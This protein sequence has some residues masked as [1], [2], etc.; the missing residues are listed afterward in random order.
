[1]S[2]QKQVT[3]ERTRM[4]PVREQAAAHVGPVSAVAVTPAGTIYSGAYD[5]RL[6]EWIRRGDS[7]VPT[8]AVYLHSKGLNCVAASPDGS[9]LV[10]G[11]S[12]GCACVVDCRTF[13][14][15][16]LEHP[17]DVEC[18]VFSD[19]GSLVLTGGTD[20]K[21][22]VFRTESGELL[23]VL[24]HGTTVG[25]ACR[26]RGLVVTGCNDRALR[27]FTWDGQ[28][29]AHAVVADGPVKAVVS[30]AAG[31]AMGSHD[32][33]LRLCGD[34]LG[35]QGVLTCFSTTPKTL[36]AEAGG[37]T[38]WVGCYDQTL[39]RWE[40]TGEGGVRRTCSFRV[41]HSWA[42][43]L[44]VGNVLAVGSFDGAPLAYDLSTD[45]PRLLGTPPA[46]V[47]C[48]SSFVNDS[49]RGRLLLAGDSGQLRERR[50]LDGREVVR[51]GHRGA[52]TAL[53]G[54]VGSMV[55]GTWDGC[56]LRLGEEGMVW[57]AR[58]P[59]GDHALC[60]VLAVDTNDSRVLAGLYTGGA[61][62]FNAANG[63]PLWFQ[64]EATGAVKSVSLLGEYFA[65]T[66]R[67]DP[68]RVGSVANGDVLAR[69]RLN[70]PVSDV[71]RFCPF[72]TPDGLHRLAVTAGNNEVWIVSFNP[73]GSSP[74][75]TVIHKCNPQPLP[76]KTLVWADPD[77]VLS[78]CYAGQIWRHCV[79]GKSTLLR[80]VDCRLGV[81]GLAVEG[82]LVMYTTFD[83]SFG[84]VTVPNDVPVADC[85][86]LPR[87]T[88]APL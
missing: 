25:A 38:F 65:I 79:G 83:G 34:D 50:R 52:V 66:G 10:T 75:L 82:N 12:D 53:V 74:R 49:R 4:S 64:M 14:W 59:G 60:P 84:E 5:G 88:G 11:G 17:G 32:C 70:T 16:R 7:L 29:L 19:D 44:A 78:G 42:H 58:W 39:S 87:S 62:C 36:V 85:L 27:I 24:S 57:Q 26:H 72:V 30:I 71:V 47:P 8:R 40:L 35:V 21:A 77:T 73:R 86:V 76:I 68:L 54:V 6:V 63:H 45:P 22:R 80:H 81:S 28:L 23:C 37:N 43:G 2:G 1:M 3:Q 61:A 55:M 51:H 69:L 18:A 9:L 56:V 33:K 67:Y 13:R 48:I 31:I 41:P 20:G 15:R 46:P